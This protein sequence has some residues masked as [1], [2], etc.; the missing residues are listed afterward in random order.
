MRWP[1]LL[2]SALIVAAGGCSPIDPV[3]TAWLERDE[4]PA[5]VTL[6]KP[7]PRP[8]DC[9]LPVFRAPAPAAAEDLQIGPALFRGQAETRARWWYRPGVVIVRHL[10]DGDDPR[11]SQRDAYAVAGEILQTGAEEL[12]A[13]G[14]FVDLPAGTDAVVSVPGFQAD[15]SILPDSLVRYGV[16]PSDGV[17]QVRCVADAARPT[18]FRIAFVVDG[19]R[20]VPVTVAAGGRSFTRQM[21]F[22]VRRC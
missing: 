20:C 12:V 22:G 14:S 6:S 19:P 7:A 11:Y 17:R 9:A 16:E 2:G 15:V 4:L 8:G 10:V 1:A 21:R 18:S 13:D 3:R 5:S